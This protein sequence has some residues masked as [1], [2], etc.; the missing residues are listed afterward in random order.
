MNTIKLLAV[1]GMMVAPLTTFAQK[2]VEDGSKFGHGEDSVRCITNLVQYGDQVK[3]KNY[4]DALEPWKIVFAECP[5][6]KGT[7]LYN[8]GIKIMKG[9]MKTDKANAATYFDFLMQIYDQRM[10]YFGNNK[11]YPTSYLK[12][13]KALD[14]YNIKGENDAKGRAEAVA[15]FDEALA[16]PIATV[17]LAFVQTYMA[18]KTKEFNENNISAEEVVNAYIKCSDLIGQIEGLN[19]PK[20]ADDIATTKA[21]V[22]QYFAHSGAADCQTIER[23]FGP[24][25][26]ANK[27]NGDWLKRINKLLGNGDCTENQLF[28]ATSEAL[29]KISPQASSARGIARMYVKQNNVDQALAYYEEAIKL[30]TDDALK[31]KYNF[32]MAAVHFANSNLAAAK[33]SC[34]NAINLRADWGDPYILLARVYAQGSRSIGEKPYE[35]AG[36]Y[37]VACDKLA[38]AKAVDSSEEVQKQA[39]ELIRQYSQYFPSKEDLFFEG[40]KDGSAYRVGGFI[41]EST[42][43]RAKK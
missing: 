28:Y 39:N 4:K 30:E 37:W 22:E 42:T 20:K 43:I 38:K 16:G 29:H 10:K 1:A 23:I 2:G 12:G 17:Q 40:L 6:A 25:L 24:Q 27:A 21:N 34:Y 41:G 26:E 3:M 19:D 18:I 32:E 5:L 35:K 36:G 11:K 15:L 31:A 8:D 9:M 33:A 7:T 14:I 13:M